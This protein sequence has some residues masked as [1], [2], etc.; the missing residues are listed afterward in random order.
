[1]PISDRVAGLDAGADDYLVKPFAFDELLARIRVLLRREQQRIE[2]GAFAWATCTL[3]FLRR[4]ARR[5]EHELDL[6][7][8]QFELLVFLMKHAN[9]IV[10]REMIAEAVWKE[11]TATWT[12][13]IAAHIYQ[14]RKKLEFPG[15]PP[16]LHTIRG[17][18]YLLGDAP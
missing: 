4:T 11:E 5:G 12:N 15:H 3:I 16:I 8:R 13:V 6:Q 14:L 10:T 18:G 1:M 17:Q 9:Q 7:S 2:D